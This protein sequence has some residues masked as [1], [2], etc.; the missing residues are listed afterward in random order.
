[1]IALKN[2]RK[3]NNTIYADYYP[4]SSKKSSQISYDIKNDIFEGELVGDCEQ[5]TRCHLGHAKW[6]LWDMAEGKRPIKDCTIM[7]V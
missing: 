2:V 1:M 3:E 5:E 4:E 6:A 7:W